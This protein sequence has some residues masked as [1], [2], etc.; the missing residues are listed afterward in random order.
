MVPGARSEGDILLTDFR[1]SSPDAVRRKQTS[2]SPLLTYF[3]LPP[4][5]SHLPCDDK[6]VYQWASLVGLKESGE[7]LADLGL[8]QPH[9]RQV[10]THKDFSL[11][12][13]PFASEHEC[14]KL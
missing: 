1:L 4:T 3:S 11:L 7:V 2:T 8:L 14:M 13:L 6:Q 9:S 10:Q 12:S 5:L